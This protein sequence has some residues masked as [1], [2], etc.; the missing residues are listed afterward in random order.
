MADIIG[1]PY[2]RSDFSPTFDTSLY[3]NHPWAGITTK[4]RM[5]YDPA[6]RDVYRWRSVFSPY[7]T[8]QQ[9]LA[10]RAAKNMTVTSLYDIHPDFNRIG[11]RDMSAPSGHFD[12]KGQEIT[13]ERYG[14]KVSYHVYDELVTYWQ[15]QGGNMSAVRR[16]VQDKL[17]QH[18]I[19]VQDMLAR[20]AMLSVPFKLYAAGASSFAGLSSD[21]KISTGQ[22]NEIHLG[23]KYRG[24]PYAQNLN[25]SVGTIV[26]ITSPG[27]I[28]D[29]QQQTD[30]K[31]WL[32]PMAYADPSRLLNYEVGTYRNVRFVE[33]PKATLFNAGVVTIQANITSAIT[34]GDGSPDPG[35]PT[36][37]VDATWKVGQPGATH[38]VQ[39]DSS[40]DMTQF[41]INDIVS[42]HVQRTSDFGVSN[43]VD[44]RD[45]K[46]TNRRIVD[47]DSTSKRLSFDQP[48]MVDMNTNLG[49]GVY[50]YVTKALHVHSCI[51][52]G[53]S[54][55]IVMG[56]GRP[57]RLHAPGPIDDF[58]SIWRFSWDSYQGYCNYN[59]N[60]LETLFVSASFRQVGA[61]LQG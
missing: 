15:Y 49:A 11:L 56:V 22:L 7:I 27:V 10:N 46:L 44:F 24:V 53:G 52:V 39:L 45:G 17:G 29:L 47:I 31:D 36:K 37:M 48:V 58:D 2:Q 28:F 4:E 26:C 35:D 20:N 50:G 5:F 51:F 21:D 61:M 41:V 38:Y 30:P 33:T 23:M 54:D 59:P 40:T 14:G 16:I 34:A 57:P 6:L 32:T 18:M 19:D 12:S 13:F 9:N 55:G 3:A 43:G 8:F 42:I 1:S 25:G 60:V